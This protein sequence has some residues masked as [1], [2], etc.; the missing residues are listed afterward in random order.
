MNI[1]NL[2]APVLKNTALKM[3]EI[4]KKEVDLLLDS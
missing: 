4:N 1:K 2:K 3:N